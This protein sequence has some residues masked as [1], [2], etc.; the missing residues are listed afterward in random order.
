[1]A[2]PIDLNRDAALVSC[3]WKEALGCCV[4]AIKANEAMEKRTRIEIKPED[5]A[6]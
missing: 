5:Y 1:M 4:A 3:S 2:V 6:L